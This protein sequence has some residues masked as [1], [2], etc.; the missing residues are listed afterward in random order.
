MARIKKEEWEGVRLPQYL[1]DPVTNR[2]FELIWENHDDGTKSFVS[3]RLS[4][5]SF[6]KVEEG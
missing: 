1:L 4:P 5:S 6:K 2:T 3:Y